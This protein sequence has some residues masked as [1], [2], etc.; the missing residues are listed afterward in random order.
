V[1]A[2][3]FHDDRAFAMVGGDGG[4][5]A[6]P[7]ATDRIRLS[8]GERAEIVVAVRAGERPVLRSYPPD[9]G[10]GLFGGRDRFD[11]LQ[12]RAAATL[13]RAAD[14]PATLADLPRRDPVVAVRSRS[15]S[16]SGTEINGRVCAGRRAGTGRPSECLPEEGSPC[17]P[18]PSS[19]SRTST[20]R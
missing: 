18:T 4:L 12:L 19:F 17:P 16:L 1:Y 5:I 13:K 2:F 15:F 11:V 7:Y 10:N 14:V 8:P 20:S 9:L 3:G 6:A